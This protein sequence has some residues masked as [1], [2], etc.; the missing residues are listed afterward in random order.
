MKKVLWVSRHD[1]TSEQISGLI[2]ILKDQFLYTKYDE[3]VKNAEELNQI[4]VENNYDAIVAVLP[5]NLLSELKK[6]NP[7]IKIIVP[8]SKRKLIKKN[9]N[10]ESKVIFEF[11]G[12]EI[13]KTL[14]YESIIVR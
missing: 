10:E 8:R 1:L 3:T 5:V 7:E 14:I 13:I 6:I 12:F 9:N 2:K 11:D 4:L